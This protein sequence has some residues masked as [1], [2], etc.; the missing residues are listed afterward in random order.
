M[1]HYDSAFYANRHAST[2]SPAKRILSLLEGHFGAPRSVFDLG[3]GVGTWLSAASELWATEEI[4]G[5][6]GP[7]VKDEELV[8]PS[9]R[10]LR[11]DLSREPDLGLSDRFDLAMCLEVAEHLP[12]ASG[13]WLVDELTRR[14]ALILFSAAVPGQGGVNH[15]NEA[16]PSYWRA[17]FEARGYHALDVLRPQIWNDDSIPF[18]YRQ[19]AIIFAGPERLER[20]QSPD[21]TGPAL[22]IVHP[23]L[24]ARTVAAARGAQGVRQ[25]WKALIASARSWASRKHSS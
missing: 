16:W 6:E 5:I 12:Q 25:S 10:I 8:I 2:G 4:L 22:D 14:S 20:G 23:V 13:P 15:V 24:F 7:W 1:A 11:F 17:L 19:N 18:W 9:D 21:A 3:C